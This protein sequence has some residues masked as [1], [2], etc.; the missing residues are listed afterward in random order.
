M[1]TLRIATTIIYKFE[2]IGEGNQVDSKELPGDLPSTAVLKE[3]CLGPIDAERYP[4]RSS[5]QC[6]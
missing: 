2:D 6:C 3:S 5:A 1:H 4:T